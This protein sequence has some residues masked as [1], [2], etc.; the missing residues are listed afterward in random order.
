M[1]FT[2]P[3]PPALNKCY[4]PSVGANGKPYTYKT[5][6]AKQWQSDAFYLMKQQMTDRRTIDSYVTLNIALHLKRDRDIDS[7][8]KLLLDTLEYAK[9]IN[10]DKQ[11]KLL[12]THK[13]KSNNPRVEIE[14]EMYRVKA[15]DPCPM[16]GAKL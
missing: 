12:I 8:H 5:K 10:N 16:C 3:L 1:K 9:V 4:R 7:S 6:T 11:I 15:S 13:H 14:I 2:L